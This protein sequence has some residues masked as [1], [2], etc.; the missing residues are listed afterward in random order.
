MRPGLLGLGSK[1]FEVCGFHNTWG[2]NALLKFY[3]Y[4]L[5]CAPY[6]TYSR[7]GGFRVWDWDSVCGALANTRLRRIASDEK[8]LPH[9][10]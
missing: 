9:V 7:K 2:P 4:V 1:G 6:S 3:E 5:S 8:L 10:V